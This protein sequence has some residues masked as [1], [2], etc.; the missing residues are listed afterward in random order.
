MRTNIKFIPDAKTITALVKLLEA[1]N[2]PH[3]DLINDPHCTI[4]YSRDIVDINK[5]VLP[6]IKYP[7]IGLY[8]KLKVLDTKDNGLCMVAIFD[9]KVAEK[10][11]LEIKQKHNLHT[12]FD[13]Y[14]PHITIKKNMIGNNINLPKIPFDLYFDRI[15]MD[16]GD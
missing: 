14:M 15:K 16:N 6:E 1:N 3:N 12:L 4:I 5:I 10:L 8:P 11:F 13:N 2:I 9:C 7:V